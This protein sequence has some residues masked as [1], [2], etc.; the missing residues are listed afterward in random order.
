MQ[1]TVLALLLVSTISISSVEAGFL[2]KKMALKT[3]TYSNYY[4]SLMTYS[5]LQIT[6]DQSFQLIEGFLHGLLNVD[7]SPIE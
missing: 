1:K 7:P 6:T 5:T 2:T 3:Q 4:E